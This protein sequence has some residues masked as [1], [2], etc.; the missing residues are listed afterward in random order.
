MGLRSA[1]IRKIK[2]LN[3]GDPGAAT[4]IRDCVRSSTA[5]LVNGVLNRAQCAAIMEEVVAQ[6]STLLVPFD[7]ENLVS[8]S[9][10]AWTDEEHPVARLMADGNDGDALFAQTRISLDGFPEHLR[11]A[12]RSGASRRASVLTEP[13]AMRCLLGGFALNEAASMFFV[14]AAGLRT[15]LHSDERHGMLLHVAGRKR[16][17]VIPARS[18]DRCPRVLRALMRLRDTAGSQ[19]ELYPAAGASAAA[20]VLDAVTRFQG[21]LSPGSA[22]FLPQRTLHDIESTSA[23]ISISLRFGKWD[24]LNN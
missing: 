16:F 8:F 2:S 11:Q 3:W 10:N 15:P 24:E 20:P 14:T 21:S 5:L 18:S 17:V 12:D 7:G 22:L 19:A 23:T 1:A 6:Q 9:R 4:A 13:A